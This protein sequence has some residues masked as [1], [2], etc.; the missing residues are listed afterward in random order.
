MLLGFDN[1]ETPAD[2]WVD[3][4]ALLKLGSRRRRLGVWLTVVWGH[5]EPLGHSLGVALAIS[6]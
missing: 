3:M 1:T 4:L 6:R 5:A 2:S